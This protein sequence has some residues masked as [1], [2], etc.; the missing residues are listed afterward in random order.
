MK[1]KILSALLVSAG[2]AA[3]AAHAADGT[4]TFTGNVIASTCNVTGGSDFSVPL[5]KVSTT[6]LTDTG[7]VAGRTPFTIALTGRAGDDAPT[8]VRAVFEAGS[9][10]DIATGR[11]NND[12]GEGKATNVQVNLLNNSQQPIHIGAAEGSQNSPVADISAD[13][14]ATL[15]YFAEYY[16]S[17]KPT[18]GAVNTKVQYSLTYQ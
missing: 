12:T 2:L 9:N 16:A 3:T 18:A 15:N 7:S 8:K 17:A 10:V 13:G 14:T 6:A 11:L 4:I 1:T 5:P